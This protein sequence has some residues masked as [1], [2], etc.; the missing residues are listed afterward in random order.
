MKL[1]SAALAILPLLLPDLL[2][3][4]PVA[5]AQFDRSTGRLCLPVLVTATGQAYDA[6]LALDGASQEFSVVSTTPTNRGMAS[7]PTYDPGTGLEI[8]LVRTSD[9]LVFRDVSLRPTSIAAGQLPRF[10]LAALRRIDTMYKASEVSVARVWNEALLDGIRRD[11]PR[12]TVHAR[13]LF[14]VSAAMY[15]AWAAF[16]GGA[17]PWLLGNTV[18]GYTCPFT[19]FPGFADIEAN[20]RQA[21]SF[22]AYR[23]MRHRFA[24]SPGAA[25]L[26]QTLDDLMLFYGYDVNDESRDYSTGSGAALGNHIADC[27]IGYGLADG[28]NETGN[29][30]SAL[31]EPSNPAL[32]ISGGGNLTMIDPDR[33]QPLAFDAYIDNLGV[34]YP[35]ATPGYMT[36]EW[37]RVKPFALRDSDLSVHARGGTDWWLYH[38]P[39]A[40]ARMSVASE[41]DDMRWSH[42]LVAIWGGH[43]D[44]GDGVMWDI[45][46][47]SIGNIPDYPETI[48]AHRDFYDLLDGGETSRGHAVNPVTGQPYEPQIVPRGDYTRVLAQFWADGPRSETPP[49]HWYTIFNAVSEHPQLV[50]RYRGEG[51]VLS[52]LEWDVKGYMA[53][54][55]ALH[56]AAITVWGIKTWYD[57]SRPI[58]VIRY[59]AERGQSTS[60]DLPNYD[61]EGFDLVPGHIEQV[62][63]GDPL[64]GE[65][66][67]N[68][69]EIKLYTWR[70][71][72]YVEDPD[73]NVA[74]VGWILAK[75]W[76]PYQA[77]KFVTPPFAGYI[78]GHSTFSRAAAEV[79][80][81]FTGDAYFPGGM[82][83][84][85]AKKDEFLVDEK[86]PSVD[87][88]LQWATYRD[89]ADQTSL[90]RI[91]GGIHPTLDDIPGRLIGAQVG[92]DAFNM[93]DTYFRGTGP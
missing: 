46:P 50:K 10:G 43:L 48:A 85:V 17:E 1:K 57:S 88:I 76:M 36:A 59:M 33:W 52:D 27:I 73:R 6:C 30:T 53:L 26:R 55:G 69:G 83:G 42:Q 71:P 29:Y 44:P 65:N 93:A 87:V 28:S 4:A 91:W 40:P 22:A 56:D 72:K 7:W 86:G 64:A 35:A 32:P 9:G 54:G 79:L 51:P 82:S 61:P 77:P 78:S 80:T 13:N 20:R 21:I 12:P 23:V 45:S 16:T 19:R 63:P 24:N 34:E 74:G 11:T 31:Y 67:E 66:G 60:P 70:G 39:G 90:S 5:E 37:G 49:G 89:A 47:G 18:D 41:L 68:V 75:D 38:D 81:L 84:F 58:S 14:H 15:D 25:T 62:Q 2:L 8:P 92:I 3:A